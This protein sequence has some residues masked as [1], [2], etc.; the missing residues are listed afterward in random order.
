MSK[1]PKLTRWFSPKVKPVRKGVYNASLFRDDD[2]FRY[3]NGRQWSMG[4]SYA[5]AGLRHYPPTELQDDLYWRGLAEQP[6]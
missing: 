4:D 1:K 6:K 3:W 5:H 2:F